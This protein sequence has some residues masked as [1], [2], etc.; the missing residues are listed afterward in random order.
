MNKYTL[1]L[2]ISSSLSYGQV[3][4]KK[5]NP[6]RDV[7]LDIN[8]TLG[9]SQPG[10]SGDPVKTISHDGLPLYWNTDDKKIVAI[11][12]NSNSNVKIRH[13]RYELD[14]KYKNREDFI[15]NVDLGINASTY[16][17]FILS[18]R[19]TKDI[20]EQI[21]D[22]DG[23]QNVSY[24]PIS[25]FQILPNRVSSDGSYLGIRSEANFKYNSW[26][27]AGNIDYVR[28]GYLGI[29]TP[30]VFLKEENGTW[31]LTADYYGVTPFSFEYHSYSSE[32]KQVSNRRPDMNFRWIVDILLV[33]VSMIKDLG[34]IDSVINY[35]ITSSESEWE[36]TN[37][38][39]TTL[40]PLRPS[41]HTY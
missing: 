20:G 34:E 10:N 15:D 7:A 37:N 5:D 17:A 41:G 22:F 16:K 1:A 12:G 4:I 38:V 13:Q 30:K 9:I 24:I 33:P 11:N 26:K 36:D 29:V 2:L 21:D 27:Y 19:I 3:G 25:A 6:A 14:I 23:T 32:H 39:E 28:Q 35:S 18:Y 8:G 40:Q 31:H